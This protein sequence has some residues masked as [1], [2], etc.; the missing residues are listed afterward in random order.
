MAKNAED[1]ITLYKAIENYAN[2]VE[3]KFKEGNILHINGTE[4]ATIQIIIGRCVKPVPQILKE[5]YSDHSDDMKLEWCYTVINQETLF[6]VQSDYFEREILEYIGKPS[7]L[8]EDINAE[9]ND[10]WKEN[11]EMSKQKIKDLQSAIDRENHDIIKFEYEIKENNKL[12]DWLQTY[13]VKRKW[14]TMLEQVGKKVT[15]AEWNEL[16]KFKKMEMTNND[17]K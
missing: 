4:F 13:E 10:A 9:N 15:K 7:P 12:I 2:T 11:I 3:P 17:E 5:K 14:Y 8:C 1:I 6:Q 16:K